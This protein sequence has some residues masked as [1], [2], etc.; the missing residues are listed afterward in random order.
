MI[1]RADGGLNASNTSE[2]MDQLSK[3]IEVG[4]RKIIVDCSGLTHVSSSGLGALVLLHRRMSDHGGDVRV[5]GLTGVVAEV[6]Q[7]TRLD[8]LFKIYPDV[9]RAR[10]SFRPAGE[11]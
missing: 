11:V 8:R 6:L 7:L 3:L 9:N 5:A 10:L 2:F 1:L 4:V